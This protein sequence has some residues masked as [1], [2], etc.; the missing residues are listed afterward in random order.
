MLRDASAAA[1]PTERS[2]AA[3][4]LNDRFGALGIFEFRVFP[5]ERTWFDRVSATQKHKS[6]RA[7]T[8]QVR[9]VKNPTCPRLLPLLD[10]TQD[11]KA[12]E[13][14]GNSGVCRNEVGGL[15]NAG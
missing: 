14:I 4:N 3:N 2:F 6:L 15:L 8:P 11:Q 7:I 10:T 5:T 12:C 1:L 9:R 13:T